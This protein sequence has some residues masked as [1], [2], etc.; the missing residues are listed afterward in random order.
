LFP[1][2]GVVV[3]GVVVGLPGGVLGEPVVCVVGAMVGVVG[4]TV[5][6]PD[7]VAVGVPDG[8]V[9]GVVVGSLSWPGA[10]VAFG[11]IV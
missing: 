3:V 11:S 10:G 9:L 6:V 7:G 4:T 8:V 5:G 1:F 2:V